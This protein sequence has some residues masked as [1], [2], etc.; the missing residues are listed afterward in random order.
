M[1]LTQWG[2]RLARAQDRTLEPA[3]S[4]RA[5]ARLVAAARVGAAQRTSSARASRRA[6]VALLA[7]AV[8]SAAL[9]LL[10]RPRRA[11]LTFSAGVDR[12]EVGR[13]VA[14]PAAAA[15]PVRF[16]DGSVLT[17]APAGRAR[18]ASADTDGA[19]IVLERGALTCSIVHRDGT[20]WRVQVGPFSVAVTGTRFEVA[21]QPDTD[22][23]RLRLEEGSVR[24][25]GPL[26]EGDRVVG[27]GEVIE[28]SLRPHPAERDGPAASSAPTIASPF[29]TSSAPDDGTAM[30]AASASAIATH[31]ARAA[32]TPSGTASASAPKPSWRELAKAGKYEAALRSAEE[33][34]FDA[35]LATADADALVSLGDT[36]R[37]AGDTAR[38]KQAYRA[39]RRRFPGTGAAAMSALSLGRLAFDHEAAFADAARW[40][41]AYL[42]EDAAG[43]LAREAAGRLIEA[44]ERDG[45]RIAARAA[46][47]R[48][49]ARWPDGPHAAK[50]RSLLP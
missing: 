36:A 37:L 6:F 47:R 26:V 18:V 35:T 20:R 44:R 4:D 39:A 50:A 43:P 19:E 7:A 14:A 12:G 34:D 27:A 42:A 49:L 22:T 2:R 17:L 25:T 1:E 29:V 41:E 24:L 32:T 46:A 15:L 5:I 48:Y 9:L 16:S 3:D 28:L 8:L 21:W 30:P 31:G 10:L 33:G 45:D 23:L 13:W 40:F 38:A 11:S